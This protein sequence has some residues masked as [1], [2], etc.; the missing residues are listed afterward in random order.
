M[1]PR[2]FQLIAN[3]ARQVC[4]L[5]LTEAKKSMVWSR[6]LKKA[7][8]LECRSFSEYYHRITEDN[9]G[10]GI[11]AMIDALTTT[12]SGFMRETMHFKF[13]RGAMALRLQTHPRTRIWSAGAATG[14]EPYSIAISLLEEFGGSIPER[15]SI[16]GTDI[17]RQALDTARN[18]IYSLSKSRALA[19]GTL[20]AYFLKGVGPFRG[21]FRVK[22]AVREMVRFRRLN[23]VERFP[24]MEPFFIIF[25]RN[26][27]I[28]F[29][30][31]TQHATV[32]RLAE[33]LE[34]GGY[35]IIGHSETLS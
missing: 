16:L 32:R 6:L 19:P 18:G 33:Y 25:C 14:E 15:V 9:T 31:Q 23:L 30:R 11:N 22:P 21:S 20:S 8:A 2:E 34:P 35:L 13:L 24:K 1:S 5:E 3:L 29:D 7:R 4:G 26:V 12:F 10:E 17:S 27:M 28:Y